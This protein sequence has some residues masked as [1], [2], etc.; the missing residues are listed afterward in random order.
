MTTTELPSRVP[1]GA[2]ARSMLPSPWTG[3]QLRETNEART[4]WM[5]TT[6]PW[7]L[8]MS[9]TCTQSVSEPSQTVEVTNPQRPVVLEGE[10]L[11]HVRVQ[12][13]PVK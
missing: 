13:Q 7:Q 4:G 2:T 8:Q 3:T 12:G 9:V 5:D 1:G 11:H 10:D 6:S